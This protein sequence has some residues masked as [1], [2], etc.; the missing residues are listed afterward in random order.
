MPRFLS[1]DECEWDAKDP[2]VI[3]RFGVDF[4]GLAPADDSITGNPTWISPPNT[5]VVTRQEAQGLVAYAFLGGGTPG[6]IHEIEV[7]VDTTQGRHLNRTMRLP[8]MQLKG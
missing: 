5:V 7:S 4:S 2:D 6:A 8:I 1:L 3:D